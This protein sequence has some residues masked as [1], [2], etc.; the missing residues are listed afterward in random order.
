MQRTTSVVLALLATLLGLFPATA[1]ASGAGTRYY[2]DAV[3]GSDDAS[4][5]SPATTFEPGV[6]AFEYRP[7]NR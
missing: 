6:G 7:R 4:G 5:R 2:V 3:R 1:E